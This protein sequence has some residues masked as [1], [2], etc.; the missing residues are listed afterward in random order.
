MEQ[1]YHYS[2]LTGVLRVGDKVK[3]VTNSEGAIISNPCDELIRGEIGEIR[4]VS[5]T[6]FRINGCGHNY[7]DYD[8]SRRLVL[9]IPA[10][11]DRNHDRISI[12]NLTNNMSQILNPNAEAML[13]KDT[14]NLIKTGYLNPD[15][16]ITD[17]ARNAIWTMALQ[18]R[19][20]E[21]SELAEAELEKEAKCK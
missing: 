8:P 9:I 18:E 7:G 5:D 12:N 15:L 4:H 2:D 21:L 20:E 13:D 17:K 19:K 16:S 11:D 6:G 1:I 10:E 14:K 3:A